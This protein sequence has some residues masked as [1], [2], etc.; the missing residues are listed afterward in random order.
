MIWLCCCF[1]GSLLNPA[2]TS[3]RILHVVQTEAMVLGRIASG[4]A[5][6]MHLNGGIAFVV[7]TGVLLSNLVLRNPQLRN[8]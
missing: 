6:V 2:N 4:T 5:V 7:A 1:T 8:P 3:T